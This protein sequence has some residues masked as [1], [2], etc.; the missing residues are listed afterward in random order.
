MHTLSRLTL[1]VL[2]IACGSAQAHPGAHSHDG[3]MAAL[4][5][6]L[7]GLDVLLALVAAGLLAAQVR[8]RNLRRDRDNLRRIAVRIGRKRPGG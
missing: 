6:Q 8:G 3:L 7:T 2:L 1:I 4:A 5:H